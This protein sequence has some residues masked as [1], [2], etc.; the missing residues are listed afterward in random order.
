MYTT[1]SKSPNPDALS[2]IFGALADPTRRA[3]LKRLSTGVHSVME[4]AE[5]FRMTQPSISKHLKVLENA[6]LVVRGRDA[7]WRPRAIRAAPLA[8]ANAYLEQFRTLWEERLDR[9]EL[10]LK[11]LQSGE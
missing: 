5:P 9:L 10:Y 7:Q 4:L 1:A 3:I 11:E 8:E 2:A 6:G